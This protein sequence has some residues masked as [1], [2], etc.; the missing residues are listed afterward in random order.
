M[1]GLGSDAADYDM[2]THAPEFLEVMAEA[3]PFIKENHVRWR[4]SPEELIQDYCSWFWNRGTMATSFAGSDIHGICLIRLFDKLGDF[5][6]PWV[7]EPSGN[8]CFVELLCCDS[9][10]AIAD[11]FEIFFKRWG[12]QEVMIW[13]RGERTEGGTPRMYRWDQYLKL[14]DRLTYGLISQYRG[15]I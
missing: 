14:T 2:K 7:H 10:L 1:R 13:D 4:N 5:L 11:C 12:R 3:V 15:E 6:K 8:F 9:P